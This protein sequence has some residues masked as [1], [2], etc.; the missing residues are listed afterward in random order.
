V[1]TIYTHCHTSGSVSYLAQD[2]ENQN[3]QVIFTGDTLFVGG[4]GR[5]FEGNASQMIYN[6]EEVYAKL[7]PSVFVYPGHEY[8]VSNL[9]VLLIQF[10][11]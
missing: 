8:T 3:H 7:D 11:Q 5:F 1:K 10:F 2:P 9:K 4:C 6:M